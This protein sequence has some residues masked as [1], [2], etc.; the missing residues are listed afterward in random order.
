MRSL[1]HESLS[2]YI[3]SIIE[4]RAAKIDTGAASRSRDE[5]P[6]DRW[7]NQEEFWKGY[8]EDRE[9]RSKE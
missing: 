6:D 2:S 9:A 8:D 4:E 3:A 7:L 5:V 1:G